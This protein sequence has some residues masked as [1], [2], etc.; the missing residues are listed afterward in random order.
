MAK[1]PPAKGT[2]KRKTRLGMPSGVREHKFC[3]LWLEHFD[4]RKAYEQAG[5][6]IKHNPAQLSAKL[7]ERFTEY[8]RP[9]R[10]Q[11]A[12]VLAERLV[13][14][15]EGILKTMARKAVFD[16]GDFVE[17]SAKPIEYEEKVKE[18]KSVMKVREWHGQ[19]V[20]AS[21]LKPFHALT[22]EQRMAVEI[23][24][25]SG[26]EVTYRLPNAREQH[27]YLTS[28]G[29]QMGLFHEKLIMERHYHRHNHA[30]LELDNVP[31]NRLQALTHE[32]LPYVGVEFAQQLGF[33]QE[34]IE[35]AAKRAEPVAEQ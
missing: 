10:E 33:T 1:R 27:T 20:F 17:T 34:E 29:R 30:H 15:Q 8:L 7:L 35:E 26:G 28:I 12:R 11:K 24:S 14:D 32:L 19:P 2:Q 3:R 23:V 18:G 9:L 16:P 5:Y 6:S 31:T 22:A 13:L 4:H 25:D 21:R